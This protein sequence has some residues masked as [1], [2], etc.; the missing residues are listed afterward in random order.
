MNAKLQHIFDAQT[1]IEH[2]QFNEFLR[3]VFS[4]S[5]LPK[6]IKLLK[7]DEINLH[8]LKICLIGRKFIRTIIFERITDSS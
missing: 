1:R 6:N 2:K 7:L 8:E 5:H 4:M 3:N